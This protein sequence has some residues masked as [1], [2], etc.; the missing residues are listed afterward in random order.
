MMDK[1]GI[2]IGQVFI[3]IVTIITFSVIMLFGY[4]AVIKIIDSGD[5]VEFFQFKK[6]LESSVKKIYTEFESVRIKEYSLPSKYTQIC[7]IDL[8]HKP[9]Q[10][11]LDSLCDLDIAACDL[12][13]TSTG[14]GSFDQ[15]VFLY[16][17]DKNTIDIKVFKIKMEN[18]FLCEP[19]HEG[20][21]NIVI[22]GRGDHT[23]I[24][25]Y[26]G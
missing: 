11:E 1:K 7:F 15:N 24:S 17:A 10:Q 23:L 26:E 4:N 12:W 18:G 9:S 22:E 2:G 5:K 16:P 13:E 20:K 6:E 3:F 25:R 8:D 14:Y 19:I 21:F